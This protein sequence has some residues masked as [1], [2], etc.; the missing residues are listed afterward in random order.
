MW[1]PLYVGD[2]LRDTSRLSTIQH[3]AYL[4]L[5]CDYWVNGPLPDDDALLAAI[6]RAPLAEWQRHIRP[7][8]AP[9]F[10]VLEGRW[11]HKRIDAELAKASARYNQRV[12]AGNASVR[13]RQRGRLRVIRHRPHD[14][15]SDD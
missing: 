9:F 13:A 15:T 8:I 6:V 12:N 4:L 7:R 1:M 3:G 10:K 11:Q 5:I 2:Y 14:E